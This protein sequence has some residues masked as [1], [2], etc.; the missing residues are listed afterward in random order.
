[1]QVTSLPLNRQGSDVLE[2][3]SPRILR[4]GFWVW[5]YKCLL[6]SPPLPVMLERIRLLR[7]TFFFLCVWS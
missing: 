2:T 3:P 6:R 7:Q 4:R 1:M 5:W